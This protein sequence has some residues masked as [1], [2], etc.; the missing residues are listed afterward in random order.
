[1]QASIFDACPIVSVS[2]SDIS[3]CT[4]KVQKISS[5][6]SSPRWSQKGAAKWFWVCV[7]SVLGEPGF[8]RINI[9][10]KLVK[11]KPYVCV[12]R[13]N[14]FKAMPTVSKVCSGHTLS[15]VFE[16]QNSDVTVSCRDLW[17]A[18]KSRCM[19]TTSVIWKC[20]TL[21]ATL[22]RTPPAS[23]RCP[24]TMTTATW[25]TRAA[26]R[27]AVWRFL[28]QSTWSVVYIR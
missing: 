20:C 5:G 26:I 18:W 27:V 9:R 1:M 16:N 2:A 6:T 17:C 13:K 24:Q 10:K 3:P 7:C 8:N 23:A 11:Q 19:F 28:T 22:R 15:S 4:H 14:F 12:S 21:S 25:P